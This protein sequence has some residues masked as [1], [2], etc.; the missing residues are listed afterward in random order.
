[1]TFG[2]LIGLI[3]LDAVLQVLVLWYSGKMI[4][5]ENKILFTDAL[6]VTAVF[7]V[8]TVP[9][10]F[11]T[12]YIGVIL[13]YIIGYLYTIKKY[14]SKTWI[15]SVIITIIILAV[16]VLIVVLINPDYFFS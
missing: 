9:L 12:G 3:I 11:S 4:L 1:M 2:N 10:F 13:L 15:K 16:N 5:G 7:V 6:K 8:I 14:F